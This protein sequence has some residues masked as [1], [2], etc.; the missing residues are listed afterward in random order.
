MMTEPSSEAK[1]QSAIRSA[2]ERI[3]RGERPLFNATFD[4]V[5]ERPPKLR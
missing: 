5:I 4:I 2:P 3:A 1:H